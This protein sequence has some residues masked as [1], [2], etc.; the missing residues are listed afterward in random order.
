MYIYQKGGTIHRLN[1]ITPTIYGHSIKRGPMAPT[2]VDSIDTYGV[3]A[4]TK[5]TKLRGSKSPVPKKQNIGMQPWHRHLCGG[6]GGNRAKGTIAKGL[7]GSHPDTPGTVFLFEPIV[8]A[9]SPPVGAPPPIGPGPAP[10]IPPSPLRVM[11]RAMV[12]HHRISNHSYGAPSRTLKQASG[13]SSPTSWYLLSGTSSTST[14]SRHKISRT[15][16][17][18]T[19]SISSRHRQ[20][21]A[22]CTTSTRQGLTGSTSA[23]TTKNTI[24]PH[25]INLKYIQSI[26]WQKIKTA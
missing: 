9:T 17:C 6:G 20:Q 5:H 14:L 15:H 13:C 18:P 11:W 8:G 24:S 12:T 21:P 16:K 19:A 22:L 2:T 10:P 7:V 1:K 3:Y 23:K 26:I 4:P 25:G